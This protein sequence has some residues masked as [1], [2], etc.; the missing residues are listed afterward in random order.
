LL[1]AGQQDARY[2]IGH[3]SDREHGPMPEVVWIPARYKVPGRDAS[4][5]GA[6]RRRGILT[7][8]FK[9]HITALS[10]TSGPTKMPSK[11]NYKYQR[12]ERDRAKKASKDSKLQE[13][14]EQAALRKASEPGEPEQ[15]EDS[16]QDPRES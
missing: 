5:M 6:Q 14:K 8:A 11:P 4:D 7:T 2:P 15:S 16:V 3:V 13:R 10:E 1:G 12:A 9:G